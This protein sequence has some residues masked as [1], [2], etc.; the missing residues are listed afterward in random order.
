[1]LA[2]C[3]SVAAITSSCEFTVYLLP[4]PANASRLNPPEMFQTTIK[5]FSKPRE[6]FFGGDGAGGDSKV[7]K[8]VTR[9]LLDTT[10]QHKLIDPQGAGAAHLCSHS[11][12]R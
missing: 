5:V 11:I 10:P 9:A 8:L 2:T 1:M 4:V 6:P 12:F 7:V 3:G